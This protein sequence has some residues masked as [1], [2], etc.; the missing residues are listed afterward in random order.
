M[1]TIIRKNKISVIVAFM[2]LF[3]FC[4]SKSSFNTYKSI[5]NASW[6]ANSKIGFEFEINDTISKRDLFIN[7]RNNKEYQF[8]NLYLITELIFPDETKIV[9]TL[10]YEMAD[11]QGKFLGTGFSDI[12]ENKLF[13]K[14]NMAFSQKGNY[15]VNI[16]Q[17]MRR[18]GQVNGI[19]FLEGITEVGFSIEKRN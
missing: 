5:E 9:D 3:T 13:Y 10:Q 1:E 12:K 19:T 8:S 15:I 4:D 7:L 17:A 11:V 16:S 6:E 14:E 2:F 18:N